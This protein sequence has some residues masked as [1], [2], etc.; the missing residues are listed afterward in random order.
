VHVF[1]LS[2]GSTL[3]VSRSRRTLSLKI[4]SA[5]KHPNLQISTCLLTFTCKIVTGAMIFRQSGTNW[6]KTSKKCTAQTRLSSWKLTAPSCTRSPTSTTSRAILRLSTSCQK[7]EV[8]R[9]SNF[10]LREHTTRWRPG[11]LSSFGMCLR[12][13]RKLTLRNQARLLQNYHLKA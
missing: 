8:C 2:G 6:Y 9:P 12:L 4:W 5:V 3:K 13:S 7:Q 1:H 11:W 10:H